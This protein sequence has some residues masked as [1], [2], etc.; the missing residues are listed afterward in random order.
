M[1]KDKGAQVKTCNRCGQGQLAWAKEE[2][3]WTL[4]PGH[5][6][7][8]L[9]TADTSKPRHNCGKEKPKRQDAPVDLGALK[10]LKCGCKVTVY[11]A[12]VDLFRVGYP[13]CPACEGFF[14]LP[15]ADDMPGPDVVDEVAA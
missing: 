8:G 10:A 14:M 12:E 2:T 1:A 3:G 11:M 4:Y 9:W 13:V 7:N 5:T 6:V 15:G